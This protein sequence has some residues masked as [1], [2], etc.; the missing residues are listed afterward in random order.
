MLEAKT[1]KFD[2]ASGMNRRAG[3]EQDWL[4]CDPSNPGGVQVG[5]TTGLEQTRS[6]DIAVQ[7]SRGI[8]EASIIDCQKS[9]LLGALSTSGESKR[10]GG[11]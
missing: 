3:G 1:T 2:K 7:E 10:R 4:E 9:Y 6:T 8:L 5:A 11:V